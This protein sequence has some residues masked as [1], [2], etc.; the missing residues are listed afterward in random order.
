M[1]FNGGTINTWTIGGPEDE[2]GGVAVVDITLLGD[3]SQ[4]LAAIVVTDVSPRPRV[5]LAVIDPRVADLTP[6]VTVSELHA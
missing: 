2:D 4:I 5:A 6:V 3:V 1:A